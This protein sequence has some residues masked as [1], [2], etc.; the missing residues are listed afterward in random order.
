MVGNPDLLLLDA[1]SEGIQ[2][3]IVADI[4]RIFQRYGPYAKPVLAIKPGD[5]VE[6]E[7]LDAF[8]GSIK[9][10]TDIPSEKFS[11]AGGRIWLRQA[12][13]AILNW[14][15]I[16]RWAGSGGIAVARGGG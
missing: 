9:S 5:I 7:T 13:T 12:S 4:R 14:R 15:R 16:G 8:G 1:P 11:M 10:E 6:V 3:S 2:P